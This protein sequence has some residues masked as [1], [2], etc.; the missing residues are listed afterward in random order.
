MNRLAVGLLAVTAL[1]FGGASCASSARSPQAVA[2]GASASG[3]PQPSCPKGSPLP[4]NQGNAID[5]VD[6]IR[7]HGVDYLA[8]GTPPTDPPKLG[9][10]LATVRC[11]AGIP[12][13]PHRGSVPV[14]DPGSTFVPAGNPIYEV[15]GKP[16]DCEVAA[17]PTDGKLQVYYVHPVG[18]MSPPCAAGSPS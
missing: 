9:R 16:I 4:P 14:V 13:D 3:Q 10:V 12:E 5:Y 1:S 8:I 18:G 6:M 7:L 17:A 11:A 15:A 2:A